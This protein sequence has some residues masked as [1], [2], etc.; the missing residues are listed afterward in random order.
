[1]CWSDSV[2]GLF[3]FAV[4]EVVPTLALL[5]SHQHRDDQVHWD[6]QLRQTLT[7]GTR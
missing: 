5:S 4:G 7:G 6:G 2:F 3:G 1:M